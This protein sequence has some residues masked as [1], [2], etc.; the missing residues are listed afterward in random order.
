MTS[1]AHRP[2]RQQ[3]ESSQIPRSALLLG[4]AGLV[5]FVLLL[6]ALAMDADERL[7]LPYGTLRDGLKFYGAVIVSF[8][9]GIRWGIGMHRE[10]LKEAASFFGM[11]VV[12]PLLAWGSL[13]ISHPF[14]LIVL[15]STVLITGGADIALV[16]QGGAPAWYG[17]LRAVLTG[18]VIVC[19]VAALALWPFMPM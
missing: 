17:K 19:L 2:P 18:A 7:G 14:D 15:I 11:S 10:N 8:L 6:I 13:L 12:P 4:L 1:D 9:G 16:G 3:G 5:P